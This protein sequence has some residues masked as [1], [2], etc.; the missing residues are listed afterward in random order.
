MVG[1]MS[2]PSRKLLPCGAPAALFACGVV[3]LVAGG[4]PGFAWTLIVVGL[5]WAAHCA[6]AAVA[7]SPSEHVCG[8]GA[9]SREQR[10]AGE[11]R[12][13]AGSRRSLSHVG[14]MG[15]SRS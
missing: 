4:P 1:A 12:H 8:S 6:S 3:L 11:R 9:G 10:V 5:G 15:R 2:G 14:A 7:G 13:L